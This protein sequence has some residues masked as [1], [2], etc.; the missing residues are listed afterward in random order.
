MNMNNPNVSYDGQYFK[1]NI[2]YIVPET[3][4]DAGYD[5]IET[6]IYHHEH[7]VYIDQYFLSIKEGETY[8]TS[9]TVESF[10]KLN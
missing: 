3:L 8:N 1:I 7:M 10:I 9:K 5:Y 4:C 6:N 2:C